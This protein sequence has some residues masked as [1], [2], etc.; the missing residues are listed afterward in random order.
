MTPETTWNPQDIKV[1]CVYMQASQRA[2]KRARL[3]LAVVLLRWKLLLPN[4]CIALVDSSGDKWVASVCH[5]LLVSPR[6]RLAVFSTAVYCGRPLSTSS[7]STQESRPE[8]YESLSDEAIADGHDRS[9]QGRKV[10]ASLMDNLCLQ[11]VS[12]WVTHQR[13]GL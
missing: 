12:S 7:Q 13:L 6:A 9:A 4:V 1:K 2:A 10:V 11:F 5:F 8:S 3:R